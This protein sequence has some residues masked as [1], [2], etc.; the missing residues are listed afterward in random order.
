MSEEEKAPR[1]VVRD[2]RAFAADGSRR[3]DAEP[4]EESP[5]DPAVSAAE[6]KPGAPGTEAATGS[7]PQ[8]EDAVADDVRIKQLVS[9]LFSQAAVLMEQMGKEGTETGPAADAQRAGQL[10]GVQTT[11][12][13]LEAIQEKT[14]GRLGPG[15]AQL[16]SNALYHLRI[17]YMERTRP[18][19]S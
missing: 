1:I 12:G 10:E 7:A 18:P 9:L 3:Q 16:V 17:A 14:K 13:I 2:R 11:I 4:R 15:D 19:G 6:P 8:P 5:P